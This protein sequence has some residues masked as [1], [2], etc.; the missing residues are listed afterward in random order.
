MKI[1]EGKA[2][3]LNKFISQLLSDF[4]KTILSSLNLCGCTCI[5]KNSFN[6][7]I[8]V[9]NYLCTFIKLFTYYYFMCIVSDYMHICVPCRCLI[10]ME[11]RR[12]HPIPWN[13]SYWQLWAT[14]HG[15]YKLNLCPAKLLNHLSSSDLYSPQT[16]IL[17]SFC[18]I[19]II[20]TFKVYNIITD[21]LGIC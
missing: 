10:F 3:S 1:F 15:Y 6:L 2:L 19:F 8:I 18:N 16:H 20:S 4:L 17:T 14:W 5:S 11:V 21:Y 12:W 9:N 7:N 13:W